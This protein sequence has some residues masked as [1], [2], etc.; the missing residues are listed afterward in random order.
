SARTAKKAGA[1]KTRRPLLASFTLEFRR[2]GRRLGTSD[3]TGGHVRKAPSSKNRLLQRVI[4][5][6]A[7]LAVVLFSAGKSGA[8]QKT[9]YLDRLTV[10]GAPDDGIAVWRPYAAPKTRVFGQMGLGLTLRPLRLS[11]VTTDG[12]SQLRN[13]N[14]AVV[15][16]QVID[17]A[18]AGIEI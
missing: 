16:S 17:Y 2:V 3:R 14:N 10:G 11:T 9:F 7:A 5:A 1:G 8:Q 15:S 18:T 13:Y 4:V 12:N 6:G